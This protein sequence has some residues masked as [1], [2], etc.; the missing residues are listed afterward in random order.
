MPDRVPDEKRRSIAE[1]YVEDDD[2]TQKET[3]D[4]F[5]V[6][7]SFVRTVLDEFDVDTGYR[8]LSETQEKAIA[9]KYTEPTVSMAQLGEEYDVSYHCISNVL[10]RQGVDKKSHSEARREYAIRKDSF[11]RPRSAS[12]YYFLG[13]MYAD[14]SVSGDRITVA[15]HVQDA[16]I[17]R[18]VRDLIQPESPV[19]DYHHDGTH[20][21]RFSLSYGEGL[22]VL[23]SY[24]VAKNKTLILEWPSGK[25]PNRHLHH[26]LRGYQDGDGSVGIRAGRFRWQ[27]VGTQ[28]FLEGAALYLERHGFHL[29]VYGIGDKPVCRGVV[30]GE[31]QIVQLYNLLYDEAEVFGERK[32]AAWKELRDTDRDGNE[33]RK[34]PV[35]VGQETHESKS[36]A[37][38]VHDIDQR[39][40]HYRVKNDTFPEWSHQD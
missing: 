33:R 38:R 1:F 28:S 10:D 36:E 8:A 24:G 35:V 11:E 6:S 29:G 17:V 26:F 40:V 9:E 32:H 12:F 21:V 3:A 2:R 37:A 14:G 4:E 19:H 22:E 7:E 25:V 30:S 20:Y 15:Q 5:G 27:I 34:K 39:T 31:N 16:D 23:N 18:Q 13:L